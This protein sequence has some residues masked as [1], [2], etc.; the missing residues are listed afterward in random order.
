MS[1]F[2]LFAL[3]LGAALTLSACGG[4]RDAPVQRAYATGPIQTACLRADRSAAN[5]QLCGCV[6]AAADAKLSSGEQSRAVRFFRDPHHAQEVRQS[7]RRR[8]EAFWK[9]Y[10]DFVS[11]AERICRVA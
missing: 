2:N 7:D 3:T 8:D 10:K 9:R 11:T 1:R 6:Q 4:G 5:R